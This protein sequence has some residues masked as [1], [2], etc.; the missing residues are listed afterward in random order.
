[1]SEI[2]Q[3]S[4]CHLSKWT[5]NSRTWGT[6]CWWGGGWGVPGQGGQCG[7]GGHAGWRVISSA[8]TKVKW[9]EGSIFGC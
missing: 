8:L 5:E 7:H 4:K 9:N 1:M 3:T 6:E 2:T